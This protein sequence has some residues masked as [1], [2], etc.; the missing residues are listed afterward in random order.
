MAKLGDV[1][2][3]VFHS[4]LT[5]LEWTVGDHRPANKCYAKIIVNKADNN[6]VIGF[7][8]LSP[9]AG[10]ITQGWAWCVGGQPGMLTMASHSLFSP[11]C[12]LQCSAT[13]RDV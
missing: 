8:V 13:W 3:E 5:P 7:H 11:L 6:R 4:A 1:N 10:E 12:V 2:I 9:H